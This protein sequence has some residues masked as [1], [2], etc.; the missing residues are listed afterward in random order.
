MDQFL[1]RIRKIARR[2]YQVEKLSVPIDIKELIKK[3]AD[4]EEAEIPFGGDAICINKENRPLIIYDINSIESRLRFTLAHELGHIKIPWHTGM[5]SCHTVDE[6]N[7]NQNE[8]QSMENEANVFASELL[9][10]TFWICEMVGKFEE[11]GLEKLTNEISIN[12]NVS[13]IAAL[14]ATINSL[15]KGYVIFIDKKFEGYIQKLL[16]NGTEALFLS[17]HGHYNKK[18]LDINSSRSGMV[19]RDNERISWFKFESKL[20]EEDIGRLLFMNHD[21][22]NLSNAFKNIFDSCEENLA[23]VMPV[24]VKKLP[25][26][27]IIKVELSN[28]EVYKYLYSNNTFVNPR[29]DSNSD[30]KLIDW[31]NNYCD[32]KGV[33]YNEKYIIK[34]WQFDI[35]T[36]ANIQSVDNRDS[37]TILRNLVDRYYYD[38]DKKHIYGKVNGVIGALNNKKLDMKPDEFYSVLKQKFLG[39]EDLENIIYDEDFDNFLVKKTEETYSK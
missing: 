13:F 23:A 9:M 8:Y 2:V 37:K 18:W 4:V 15:P 28:D 27:Y 25:P 10:P 34:W 33:Y 14:Y 29:L 1:E 3:Y 11:F 31:Y 19:I 17:E 36:E 32:T 6:Q 22:I 16:S 38:E 20:S 7:I 5:I 39:R 24:I 12:A 26:G 21:R 35:I 30:P